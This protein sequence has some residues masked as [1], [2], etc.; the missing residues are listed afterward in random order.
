MP[1]SSRLTPS[2]LATAALLAWGALPDDPAKGTSMR[3]RDLLR[4]DLPSRVDYEQM[5]RGYY[6]QILDASRHLGVGSVAD[7]A[8][9][10]SSTSGNPQHE[11]LTLKVND[12]R[13]FILKPNLVRDEIK[14][15]CW[16]TNSFGM[17]DRE[18][19]QVKPPGTFRIG[20]AGDSI[21]TGW[22][23]DDDEG[24]EPLLE[25]AFDARAKAAGGPKVEIL[26]FAVPGHGPG[27]RWSHFTTL[28]WSFTPD[29]VIYEATMADVGWDDRRLRG[30]LSRGIG[31]DVPIYHDTLAAAKIKPGLLPDEYRHVLKPL[32]WEIL[33]G[34][35][36]QA[37][38]DCASHGV[39]LIFVLIP[40]VGKPLEPIERMK[41]LRLA[42]AAG[43]TSVIDASDAYADADPRT[44]AV[45]PHDFHPNSR[46]HALIARALDKALSAHPEINALWRVQSPLGVSSR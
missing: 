2:L 22:K 27:Q 21:A 13:E 28:G 4:N 6:E 11:R 45:S 18:Y 23:V 30:L 9:V 1:R 29:L 41:L 46:G 8:N 35:Y 17:R 32:R 36:R 20:I 31:F 5:E 34:V 37:A 40:R 44:L 15:I 24:F 12:I 7:A 10:N 42:D 39:P 3:W 19:P 14:E 38:A 33:A 25:K 43:F 26:N 16:S